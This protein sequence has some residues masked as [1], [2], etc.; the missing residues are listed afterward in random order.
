MPLSSRC[1]GLPR[2]LANGYPCSLLIDQ[3]T[4]VYFPSETVY[5]EA[6]GFIEKTAAML[7]LLRFVAYS[8][9]CVTLPQRFR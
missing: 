9:S 4:Q 7:T 8:Y 5:K 3:P 1:I 6:A 2:I